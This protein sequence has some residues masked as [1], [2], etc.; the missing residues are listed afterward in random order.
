MIV[1]M[2]QNDAPLLH[3]ISGAPD[4]LPD[5]DAVRVGQQNFHHFL[6]CISE[7]F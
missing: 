5:A 1:V 3:T 7:D 4:A 2:S 6:F